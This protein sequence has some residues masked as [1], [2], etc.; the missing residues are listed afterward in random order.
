MIILD[1]DVAI[2]ILHNKIDFNL[3]SNFISHEDRLG[4]TSP[5][6]YEIYF[7]YHMWKY[8][9]NMK[10]SSD[11]LD[12]E[13]LDI[14][15]LISKLIQIPFD[16]SSAIK[17]SEIYNALTAEGQKIDVFDCMIAGTI[18]SHGYIKILTNNIKHY[19][20]ITELKVIPLSNFI[21]QRNSEK[22]M[23]NID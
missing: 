11:D 13:L 20:R 4:I 17:S 14:D 1:S 9:K 22:K 10:K 2:A 18:I 19:S 7:G 21:L 5:S 16:G 8:S 15:K 3:F 6:I 12:K 23:K